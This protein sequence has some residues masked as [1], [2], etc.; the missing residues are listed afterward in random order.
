MVGMAGRKSQTIMATINEVLTKLLVVGTTDQDADV[1][2]CVMSCLDECFNYHLAQAENLSVLFIAL[3]DEVFEIREQVICIIGRLSSLNPAYIMPY[4]RMTLIQLSTEMECSG[5]GRNQEQSARMFGY[6]VANAPDLIRPYV[7]PILQVL[8]PKLKESDLNPMVITSVLRAVGDL[9]HVGGTLMRKY[10]DELLPLL[11]DMLND[12]SSS[13]KRE[14][15]STTQ[16]R[17]HRPPGPD[18]PLFS[19]LF[20]SACGLWLS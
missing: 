13:Q 7:D 9:A 2:A 20:S 1:R 4:L 17:G 19:P 3:N 18:P 15:S 10:L 5:N 6:L 8:I 16:A 11:L 12:A 14:V